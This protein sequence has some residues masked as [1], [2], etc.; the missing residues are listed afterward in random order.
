M[1]GFYLNRE[2]LNKMLKEMALNGQENLM[3]TYDL[4]HMSS[5]KFKRDISRRK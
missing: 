4:F 5:G 1:T 2:L 3:Y